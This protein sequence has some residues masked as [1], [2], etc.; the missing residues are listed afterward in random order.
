MKRR[1][2]EKGARSERI[3]VIPNWV[4]TKE[5]TPQPRDNPWAREHGLVDAFV[6]MHSGNIGH[7]QDLDSLVRAATFLR[8]VDSLR[9]VSAGFGARHAEL[10]AL[11]RRLEVTSAVRFL[12]YQPREV[13][14]QSL[15]SADLHFVGLAKGLSGFV[16]PSRIYGILA[17]G[18]PVLVAADEDSETVRIVRDAGCG[19]VLPPGRPDLVAGAI[20]DAVEGGRALAGMGEAGRAYVV[21]EA[22][23]EIAFARY[24]RLVWETLA[25]SSR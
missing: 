20:R 24:R 9:I 10:T 22:D 18:R 14:A 7:A 15:S 8:D 3:T 11:A 25:S 21:R 17:A 5:I 13:L 6:V 16:V 2:E 4:D 1:L 12:P 19:L 23:R